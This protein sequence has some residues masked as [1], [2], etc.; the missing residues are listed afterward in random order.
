MGDDDIDVSGL[1]LDDQL[2]EGGVN[3]SLG[4]G[5]AQEVRLLATVED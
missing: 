4:H 5:F 2:E 1:E 3:D